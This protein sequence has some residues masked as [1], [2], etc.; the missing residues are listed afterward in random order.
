[1]PNLHVFFTRFK[2]YIAYLQNAY[3]WRAVNFSKIEA[4][5][6]KILPTSPCTTTPAT[7][8]TSN[9]STFKTPST[10]IPFTLPPKASSSKMTRNYFNTEKGDEYV[11]IDINRSENKNGFSCWMENAAKVDGRK[12]KVDVLVICQPVGDIDDV[13]WHDCTILK[14]KNVLLMRAP[15]HRSSDLNTDVMF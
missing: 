3:S 4:P 10:K 15:K 12:K 6:G 14:S 13:K 8:T 1:M 7:T 11:D 2:K 5:S 9:T